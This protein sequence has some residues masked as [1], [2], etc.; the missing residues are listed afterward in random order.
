MT[1]KEKKFTSLYKQYGSSIHKLCL[2][3]TGDTD[4]AKDLLQETF[5]SVWNHL[6]SFREEASWSTWIYRIAVN[7]CLLNLR[8]K[9]VA[10]TTVP[11]EGFQEYSEETNANEKEEEILKLYGCISKLK[12]SDRVLIML[13]LEQ[14]A[15][16]EIAMITGITETHL[17]VKIHRIKKELTALYHD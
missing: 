3:Y 9:K 8:K 10:I 17:R 2:G 11:I 13:G 7:T 14:R 4:L 16:A 12:A 6:E 1:A 5:I 15:Y